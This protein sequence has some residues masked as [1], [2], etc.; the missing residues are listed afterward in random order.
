MI[1]TPQQTMHRSLNKLL[2]H[3]VTFIVEDAQAV[4]NEYG[5]Y[6]DDDWEN[7]HIA[8]AWIATEQP[9]EDRRDSREQLIR[10]WMI[11]IAPPKYQDLSNALRV[12]F[13]I[14]NESQPIKADV[15]R[16]L[17]RFDLKGNLDRL[18]FHVLEADR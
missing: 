13:Q 1:T 11:M 6:D 3:D 15:E 4:K 18:V 12:E 2:V 7:Y 5:L 9:Y 14:D 17:K 8:K 10:R 16:V